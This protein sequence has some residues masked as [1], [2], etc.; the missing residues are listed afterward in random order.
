MKKKIDASNTKS[1]K[2]IDGSDAII[3]LESLE[4]ES[5]SSIGPTNNNFTFLNF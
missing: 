4:I 2:I 5:L 3:F 1:V